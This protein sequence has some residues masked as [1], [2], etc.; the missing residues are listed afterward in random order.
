MKLKLKKVQ[1]S[2]SVEKSLFL[3]S[4]E[5]RILKTLLFAIQQKK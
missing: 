3:I 1:Y 2:D 4:S 5:I